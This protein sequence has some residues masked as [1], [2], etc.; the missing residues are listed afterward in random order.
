MYFVIFNE[1]FYKCQVDWLSKLKALWIFTDFLSTFEK[2]IVDY[3]IWTTPFA[4]MIYEIL[5][6]LSVLVSTALK[7]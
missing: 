7:L 6:D 2:D 4:I 1:L 5:K 3:G